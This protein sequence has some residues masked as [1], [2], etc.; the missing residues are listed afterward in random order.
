MYMRYV[1]TPTYK[2][3]DRI[4]ENQTF[5]MIIVCTVYNSYYQ[6]VSFIPVI[7]INVEDRGKFI[8]ALSALSL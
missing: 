1:H 7:E 2:I 4:Y 3:C 8:D 6:F 5:E